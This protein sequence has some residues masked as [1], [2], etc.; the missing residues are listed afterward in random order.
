VGDNPPGQ[1]TFEVRRAKNASGQWE[2]EL[3]YIEF[4]ERCQ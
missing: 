3:G 1:V 4:A 2:F